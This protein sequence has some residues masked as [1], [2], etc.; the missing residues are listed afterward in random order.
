MHAESTPSSDICRDLPKPSK[1]K[2]SKVKASDLPALD[3]TAPKLEHLAK[4]RPKRAKTRAATRPTVRS[5]G[6][7]I[8]KLAENEEEDLEG[9]FETKSIAKD[10]TRPD[11]A[12]AKVKATEPRSVG[13]HS[14]L[15]LH[16]NSVHVW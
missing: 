1:P 2:S 7:L 15:Y 3:S 12:P 9:F 11:S 8:E 10:V 6:L 4:T 13:E 5:E 16:C 14:V